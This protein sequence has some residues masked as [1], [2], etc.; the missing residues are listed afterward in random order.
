M[1]KLAFILLPLALTSVTPAHAV[2][3]CLFW[4]YCAAPV[5]DGAVKQKTT[6]WYTGL[7]WEL[8]G[9]HGMK[10]DIVFGVRSLSVKNIDSVSGGDANLRFR[11]KD[12]SLSLDS[13]RLAYVSGKPSALA[14]AG[15]GYSFTHSSPIVTG[16]V[17]GGYLRLSSDYLFNQNKFQFFGELNTLKKPEK[18]GS[19]QLSCANP[20]F[21]LGD[22]DDTVPSSAIVNGKTCWGV[23]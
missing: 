5:S 11:I 17:Q 2:A 3:D 23:T 21:V 18:A 22:A 15:L 9:Q 7:V 4:Q 19:G 10:P 8:G 6:R 14:N 13:A 16:A 12:S 1:K 20:D